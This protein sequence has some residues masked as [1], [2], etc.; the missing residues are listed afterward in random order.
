MFLICICRFFCYYNYRTQKCY[1]SPE[2]FLVSLHSTLN[3][4]DNIIFKYK[5]QN[6]LKINVWNLI[7]CYK[8][9]QHGNAYSPFRNKKTGGDGWWS[10]MLV[11]V[12]ILNITSDL[13]MIILVWLVLYV[14]LYFMYLIFYQ[15][16]LNQ[17]ISRLS[18]RC[19]RWRHYN[20]VYSAL[21]VSFHGSFI[22]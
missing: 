21:D 8:I 22:C 13:I 9:L 1:H 18:A 20:S 11:V 17:K 19:P 6:V 14:Y 5:R 15:K 3:I 4:I 10:D 2:M 7:E 16:R 12:L